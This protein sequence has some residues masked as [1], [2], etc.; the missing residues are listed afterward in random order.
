MIYNVRGTSGSGKTHLLRQIVN[1]YDGAEITDETGKIFGYRLPARLRVLGRYDDAIKGGGVDNITGALV[2]RFAASGGKGNSMDAIEAQV[3]RWAGAGHHVLFEGLIV[4]G[5]WGR[6][7]ALARELPVHFLFLDTP[8]GVCYE[9]VMARNGGKPIKGWPGGSD[10]EAKHRSTER[11]ASSI[12]KGAAA[13]E[14]QLKKVRSQSTLED[15]H[16]RQIER[17]IPKASAGELRYTILDH[18]CAFDQLREILEAEIPGLEA[19][20]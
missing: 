20:R 8:L 10:L 3:R 14:R 11:Q 2:K 13:A 7:E 4:T 5:V 16:N 17:Q 15:F 6:W 12:S 18:T 9:R 1:H 19:S